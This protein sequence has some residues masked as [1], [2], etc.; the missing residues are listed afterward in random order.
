MRWARNAV[1]PVKNLGLWLENGIMWRSEKG[2]NG[3]INRAE[4]QTSEGRAM[5][6]STRNFLKGAI[7]AIVLMAMS[8]LLCSCA[9]PI[10]NPQPQRFAKSIDAFAQQDREAPF[11]KGGIVFVGSSSVKRLGLPAKTGTGNVL[12]KAGCTCTRFYSQETK[13]DPPSH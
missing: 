12:P 1:N 10:E 6:K 5:N 3:A 2:Q 9:H 7:A 8:V 4:T 13:K 11:A